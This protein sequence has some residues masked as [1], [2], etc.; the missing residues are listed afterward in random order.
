MVEEYDDEAHTAAIR[1]KAIHRTTIAGGEQKV[2]DGSETA[3]VGQQEISDGQRKDAIANQVVE[4]QTRLRLNEIYRDVEEIKNRLPPNPPS[5][6]IIVTP[7]EEALLAGLGAVTCCNV[8]AAAAEASR[9][10]WMFVQDNGSIL[11]QEELAAAIRGSA[12]RD[13]R[14]TH[15]YADAVVVTVDRLVLPPGHPTPHRREALKHAHRILAAAGDCARDSHTKGNTIVTSCYPPALASTEVLRDVSHLTTL[16]LGSSP[17]FADAMR[18]QS[19]ALA[20]S[21]AAFNKV[22]DMQRQDALGLAITA[23][24]AADVLNRR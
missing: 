8:T 7:I 15:A 23:R 6:P 1:A 21:L 14:D 20:Y 10:I 16:L 4:E 12:T 3:A 18:M 9:Y 22:G 11:T 19:D 13:L 17:A 2:S 5:P 24:T